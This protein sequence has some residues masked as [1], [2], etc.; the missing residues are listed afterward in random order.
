M[1]NAPLMSSGAPQVEQELGEE[2]CSVGALSRPLWEIREGLSKELEASMIP[3]PPKLR[4]VNV[5]ANM[6]CH[7]TIA[8]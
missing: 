2:T 1:Q 8:I 3:F 6:L 4:R 7:R 5:P